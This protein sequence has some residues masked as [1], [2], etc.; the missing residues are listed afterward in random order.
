VTLTFNPA[1]SRT[2]T[3]AASAAGAHALSFHDGGALYSRS[4]FDLNNRPPKIS[5][6]INA[7]ASVR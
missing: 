6:Y 5:R 1:M 7:P 4:D 3:A 2:L